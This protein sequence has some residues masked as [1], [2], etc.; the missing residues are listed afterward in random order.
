MHQSN[1]KRK[2]LILYECTRLGHYEEC[3]LST[4]EA[5]NFPTF[6]MYPS[7][8]EKICF[9]LHSSTKIKA[10]AILKFVRIEKKI[11]ILK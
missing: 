9:F 2:I 6:I 5:L 10:F 8:L 4:I 11:R 1:G 3:E 7:V